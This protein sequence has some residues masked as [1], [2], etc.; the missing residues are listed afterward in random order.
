VKIYVIGDYDSVTDVV[1]TPEEAV[2]AYYRV[3]VKDNGVWLSVW[4]N[5]EV[6]T[7]EVYNKLPRGRW[8]R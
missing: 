4:E 7:D 3:M 6:V 2:D 1:L 8:G 5:N